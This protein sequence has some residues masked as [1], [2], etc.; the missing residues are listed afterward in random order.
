MYYWIAQ[1]V[2]FLQWYKASGDGRKTRFLIC[3]TRLAVW[4]PKARGSTIP[5]ASCRLSPIS[6][7]LFLHRTQPSQQLPRYFDWFRLAQ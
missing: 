4:Y 5:L 1:M 6:D 2:R 7:K 3:S